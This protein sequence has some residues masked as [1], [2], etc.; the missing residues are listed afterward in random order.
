MYKRIKRISEFFNKE[1][2]NS[3]LSIN[4][5]LIKKF[6]L[7]K[8]WLIENGAIFTKNIDFP[9]AYGP[10]NLIGCKCI[11]E[12]KENESILLIPKKLMIIS[13]ELTYLD[14]AM[15]YI[16]EK[17]YDDNDIPA[18]YLTLH[19]Y[20][21]NKKKNSFFRPYLD[22]LFS[23]YNFLNDFNEENMKYFEN[24]EKIIESIND[25]CEDIN[26][27]YNLINKSN[28]FN[29]MTK[30]EFFFCYSQVISRQFYIDQKSTALIPL[31]DLLNH[32]NINIHN[33]FY[34]SENYVFKY[35]THFSEELDI[36]IDLRPTFI[37]EYP[38]MSNNKIILKLSEPF[39]LKN[40]KKEIN[41]K[42]IEI[43]D[44]YYFS[45]STSKGEIIKKGNQAFNNYTNNGNKYLL[46]YDG[47][48]LIDNKYDYTPIIINIETGNDIY[49]HKY[50]DTIF[51]KIY[52]ITDS[53]KKYLKIKIY[54]NEV[55]FYLIKYY[56][57]LYFYKEKN[58]MKQYINY[59]FDIELEISFISSSIEYLKFELNI[60]NNKTNVEK[61]LDVLEKELFNN[62]ENKPNSFKI[63]ALIYNIKQKINI[64]NQIE[65]LEWLLSIMRK[66]KNKINSY[67]N[68]LD[69]EN[70]F[71]NISQ[72]DTDEN[73]KIKVINFIKKSK[74]I[75]G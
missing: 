58:D 66:Y 8:K 51:G 23:N 46:K 63:N 40:E 73:S 71:N 18:I 54:F 68:L 62:E 20:L 69:Y 10:F 41:K 36:N 61:E 9:Y 38:L 4:P 70:E 48:C 53:F 6:D 50:L 15:E 27:L 12:I 5:E 24:N 75:I 55:C 1:Q 56:R 16:K 47:F 32:S 57:F 52:K 34:D 44:N 64:I 67:I 13:K 35:S 31:A 19:L 30:N 59:K 26:E 28:Y 17:I 39:N 72:C 37:K 25:F 33:E 29:E 43:N 22:L 65:I 49:L 11:S 2:K 21:E 7:F 74:N 14:E 60:L 45:I 3:L 42:I